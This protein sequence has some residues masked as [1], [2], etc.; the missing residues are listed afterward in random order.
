MNCPECGIPVEP[1]AHFCPKCFARLEPPGLWRRLLERFQ[2][3][4]KSPGKSPLVRADPQPSQ[5]QFP[6][7]SPVRIVDLKKSVTI[8]SLDKQGQQHEYHSLDELP[9][10]LRAEMDK[11]GASALMANAGSAHGIISLRKAEVYKVKDAAGN[12]RIYHSL[13]E[14]PPE[15]RAKVERALKKIT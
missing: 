3:I 12:E 1:D 11:L 7:N 15:I 2:S 9:P 6:G 14:L 8:K 5:F 4:G 13:D 10:A